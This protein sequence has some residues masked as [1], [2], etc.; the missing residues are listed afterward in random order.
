MPRFLYEGDRITED[1]TPASLEMEDNGLYSFACIISYA[2]MV[3]N[4]I[5]FCEL[6]IQSMLWW[7]VSLVLMRDIRICSDSHL[8]FILSEVGGSTFY[9]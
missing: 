8:R 5:R 9:S 6:Q 7:N 2:D 3:L 4:F 1:A